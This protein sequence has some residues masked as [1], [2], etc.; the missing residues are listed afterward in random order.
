MSAVMWTTGILLSLALLAWPLWSKNVLGILLRAERISLFLP[1][2]EIFPRTNHCSLRKPYVTLLLTEVFLISLVPPWV[3]SPRLHG[4]LTAV[5][6]QR[7]EQTFWLK[8]SVPHIRE[9]V[10]KTAVQP[11]KTIRDSKSQKDSDRDSAAKTASAC[12]NHESPGLTACCPWSQW[13]MVRR[14][15]AFFPVASNKVISLLKGVDNKPL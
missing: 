6:N 15:T 13:P 4:Q 1:H 7:P 2:E 11:P 10:V 12:T 5:W 9:E 8:A 3:H 14:E